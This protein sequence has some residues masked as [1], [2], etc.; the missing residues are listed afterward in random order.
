MVNAKPVSSDSAKPDIDALKRTDEWLRRF[1]PQG[2]F[3]AT[4]LDREHWLCFGLPERLPVLMSGRFAYMSKHPAATPVRLVDERHLRLSG[5][6]WPEARRRWANTAYAA[7][8]SLGHGQ[9]ILFHSDPF[10][11]C[12]CEGSGRLLLN[13]ILLGPGL[14]TDAPLPW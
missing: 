3:V 9:I 1:H 8:E 13:A 11:R 4:S 12:Y 10:F 2:A 14:G 5:L 7:V 6:L